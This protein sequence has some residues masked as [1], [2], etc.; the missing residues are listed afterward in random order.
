MTER[1]FREDGLLTTYD[2][3]GKVVSET[4]TVNCGHCGLPIPWNMMKF[5]GFCGNCNKFYH[6]DKCE[7]CVPMEQMLENF[8][9][10]RDPSFRPSRV[11]AK[12]FSGAKFSPLFGTK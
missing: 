10:G 4:R 1:L 9:A 5:A 7:C 6:G 12:Q 8:E 11:G 3:D 2:A